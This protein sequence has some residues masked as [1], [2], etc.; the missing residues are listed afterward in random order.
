MSA[1]G[2]FRRRFR[3]DRAADRGSAAALSAPRGRDRR[4]PA[5][6]SQGMTL[7]GVTKRVGAETRLYDVN[8]GRQPGNF[9]VLLG[10]TLA[11]KT[12]LMGPMAGLDRP[13]EGACRGGGLGR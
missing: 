6:R 1:N 3:L 11:G 12:S 7:D 13:S 5:G 2:I 4:H 8:L 10:L 9:D